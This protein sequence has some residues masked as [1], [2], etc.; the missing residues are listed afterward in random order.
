[1]SNGAALLHRAMDY[2]AKGMPVFPCALDKR[3]LTQ[4][5]FKD[6][7]A[8]PVQVREFWQYNPGASI[9]YPTGHTCWVLDVDL[10]K[11]PGDP[12]G[13]DTLA[14]LEAKHGPLPATVEQQTGSGG[15]HLFFNMPEGRDIK[16]SAKAIGPG[17]DVRA[18][19][20]YVIL[21]PSNH[22]SGKEYKWLKTPSTGTPYADAPEW[23][24]DLVAPKP[25][26]REHKPLKLA[27]EAGT[28]NY[29]RTALEAEA[30]A[31]AYSGNGTRNQ[32]LNTAAFSCGQLIAG[33]ELDRNEATELLMYSAISCGLG[34]VEA[35]MTIA[36]GFRGGEKEPRTCPEKINSINSIN[37]TSTI[38]F[39]NHST[40]F[41]TDSTVS[42]QDLES[43]QEFS[44][45]LLGEVRGFV[46]RTSGTF[47]LRDVDSELGI[48]SA[49][50][51]RRRSDCLYRLI[52]EGRIKKDETT[53]GKFHTV[54]SSCEW[55]D[56]STPS[57]ECDYPCT[58]P[59][60]LSDLVIL[61]PKGIVLVAGT[62]S[63]GKTAIALELMRLNL[64]KDLGLMYLPSEMG[65]SE[66][67]N[68]AGK[69]GLP[70]SQWQEMKVP[71]DNKSSFGA[72]IQHHNPNGLTVVDYLEERDGEYF[73]MASYIRDIYDSLGDGVA[74]ICVQK[75]SGSAFGR[76]GEAVN[77]KPRLVINLDNLLDANTCQVCSVRLAK[78]KIPRKEGTNPQGMERHFTL[79]NG[80]KI[81]YLTDWIRCDDKKREAYVAQYKQRFMGNGQAP[82]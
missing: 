64:G 63:A 19:G 39:D 38:P 12:D 47:L 49:I 44:G 75:K 65:V 41:D 55:V 62:T 20:G 33:G 40:S 57:V 30:Q 79:T 16:N 68:R 23:L 46:E 82:W 43:M 66:M 37:S 80:W 56:W 8:D 13:R 59:L 1:M 50:L 71:K 48:K 35:R 58:L 51:K 67:K 21:A 11:K 28:T 29:G 2:A 69:F 73:K 18:L 4:N 54:D 14:N 32:T 24:L 9:G 77:E 61:P 72:R 5:G 31:V 60:G 25:M 10:P 15:R 27:R 45:N 74:W 36:S 42:T 52:K 81:E 6:A 78:A 76:G 34:E 7:S 22:P 53:G 70:M 17:L 3:P 26:Q